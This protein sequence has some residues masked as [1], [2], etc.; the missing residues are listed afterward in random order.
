MRSH[1][2]RADVAANNNPATA[3]HGHGNNDALGDPTAAA[4]SRRARDFHVAIEE[5]IDDLLE[6][7][8]N[9]AGTNFGS[10]FCNVSAGLHSHRSLAQFAHCSVRKQPHFQAPRCRTLTVSATWLSSA[11]CVYLSIYLLHAHDWVS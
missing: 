8:V 1:L 9:N 2:L 7:A 10:D 6:D 4:E 11:R 3:N 5:G